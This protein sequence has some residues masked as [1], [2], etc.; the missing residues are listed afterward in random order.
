[1]IKRILAALLAAILLTAC[2][3]WAEEEIYPW[4]DFELDAYGGTMIL[5]YTDGT[6]E[7]TDAW[8][9]GS[10]ITED[11]MTIGDL[12]N[13]FEVA[14]VEIL[15]DTDAFEGWLVFDYAV[16]GVDEFGWEEYDHILR[17]E[18][19]ITTEELM[20]A[21]AQEGYTIFT[22][23][24]AGIPAGEYYAQA[25][26]EDYE[27]IHMPSATLYAGEGVFLMDGEEEDYES[28]LNVATIEPGQTVHEALELDKL[29]DVRCEGREFAGWTVYDVAWMETIEG[30]P[31]E[32][33]LP[34][35]EVFDGWYCVLWDYSVIG[36]NMSTGEMGE[37]IC[38]EGDLLIWANWK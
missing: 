9:F 12:L 38:G 18:V 32:E 29:L 23:K 7:E 26:E 16:T 35:F 1:M 15:S 22:A 13:H 5:T 36:E 3:C 17:S 2:T 21:P 31:E 30:M 20:A 37:L 11:G 4:C 10:D 14:D 28:A 6:R 27:T 24:W 25:A 19:P 33:G 8:G 34:C